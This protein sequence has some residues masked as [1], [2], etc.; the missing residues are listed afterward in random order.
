MNL[1]TPVNISRR[2]FN[3]RLGTA[4]GGLGLLGIPELGM[5]ETN[6]DKKLGVAL[7]GLGNY[8]GGQ[9]APALQETKHCE[10][11][12]LVS[13]SPE[14]AKKWADQYGVPIKNI[15][16]YQNYD[17]ISDNEDIDIVY[18][19]LPNSMHAEYAIR[20]AQAGKHVLCE[21]PMAISVDQCNQMINECARANRKLS[22]GYRLHFEPHNQEAMR[23][24]QNKVYGDVKVIDANFGFKIGD[25]TQWRLK[26]DLA[27]GGALM[28][29]GIYCIQAARYVTGEEPISVT[30]Q[31]YKTDPVKFAEVD[32][33]LSFQLTFPSGAVST[34]TTT[35][36]TNIHGLYVAATDGWFSLKPAYTYGPIY[37]ETKD[38]KMDFPQVNHQ[39][40]QMDSFAQSIK[41]DRANKATGAEGLKDM[42]VIEGIFQAVETGAKVK[43]DI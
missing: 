31:E 9:L 18:V 38:G 21:K 25:P 3:Q 28:D 26:K 43:L 10:L 39:A 17:S 5:A 41:E 40:L 15:Y 33:T 16:N 30:A 11:R 23:L 22:I 12:G 4:V 7:V 37:G 6:Q 42:K 27:G 2:N 29:V 32:E 36:A 1:L 20:A 8:A 24:G 14:K 19:V 13:G 34:T 35:Y